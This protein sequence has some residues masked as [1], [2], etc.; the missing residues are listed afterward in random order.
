MCP[1]GWGRPQTLVLRHERGQVRASRVPAP[2]RHDGALEMPALPSPD[3]DVARLVSWRGV[4]PVVL[5]LLAGWVLIGLEANAEEVPASVDSADAVCLACHEEPNVLTILRSPHGR[6]ADPGAPFAGESC[7]AC[8]GPSLAHL[9]RPVQRGGKRAPPDVSFGPR[10]PTP[11]SHQSSACLGCHQG[12]GLT[13][14]HDGAHPA[15]ELS[16][17]SCHSSHTDRDAVLVKATQADVCFTCHVEQRA[18][19]NLRSRH[20][21][22]EGLMSCGDCHNAHGTTSPFLLKEATVNETCFQCHADFRGPFLWEHPPVVDDCGNCHSAHGSANAALLAVRA[23][24]LCQTCHAE[25]RHP[26]TL[27]SGLGL[28]SGAPSDRLLA[29]NCMNCHSKVHGSNHPSG[30]GF[31][32]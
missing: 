26:S 14:W 27:Y 28:P 20:P 19:V 32:R 29:R 22:R 10:S 4:R 3:S 8:H 6:V 15:A 30:V 18:Q 11:V 17:A 7:Q 16:C 13:H 1:E 25:V 2:S 5:A 31:T 23:P 9:E 12:R 21:L 24:F